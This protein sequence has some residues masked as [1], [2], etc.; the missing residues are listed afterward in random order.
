[1]KKYILRKDK[2]RSKE[3]KVLGVCIPSLFREKFLYYKM[4][5]TVRKRRIPYSVRKMNNGSKT[6]TI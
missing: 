6:Y 5:F 1:M 3:K 4:Y 2:L